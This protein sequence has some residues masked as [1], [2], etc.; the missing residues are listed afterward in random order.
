MIRAFLI[1]VVVAST[2]LKSTR[3][4]AA[5]DGDLRLNVGMFDEGLIIPF[6]TG[7]ASI[8]VHPGGVFGAELYY[9]KGEHHHLF[10]TLN[11]GYYYH[12]GYEH[13]LFVDTEFGYRYLGSIG[14][15]VEGLLGTGYLH[16]FRDGTTFVFDKSSGEYQKAANGGRP[17]AMAPALTIGTGF[18][19]S[20]KVNLP[21]AIYLRYQAILEWPR[22]PENVK[23]VMSH[24]A[25]YVGFL[26]N[27]GRI[28]F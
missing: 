26:I 28:E 4:F 15:Y 12:R 20:P 24:A 16:T 6:Y 1:I 5:I 18:D 21:V 25:L 11:L 3:V 19:F 2:T 9:R 8:P 23:S 7:F 14:I 10:Q 22:C 17:H 13:G 27:I